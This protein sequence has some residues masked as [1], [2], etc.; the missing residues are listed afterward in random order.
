MSCMNNRRQ[1]PLFT[2]TVHACILD[3]SAITSHQGHRLCQ[4]GAKKVC[5]WMVLLLTLGDPIY[6][7]S[8]LRH[9]TRHRMTQDRSRLCPTATKPNR[10]YHPTIFK[11][12]LAQLLTACNVHFYGPGSWNELKSMIIARAGLFSDR[13]VARRIS[14]CSSLG[15]CARTGN[16]KRAYRSSGRPCAYR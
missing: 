16:R 5:K 8:D 14:N 3:L 12:R 9:L 4:A 11:D 2:A 7:V 13:L 6:I 15:I 1:I 10:L